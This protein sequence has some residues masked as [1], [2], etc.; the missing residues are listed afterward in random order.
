MAVVVVIVA[1]AFAVATWPMEVAVSGTAEVARDG[2][3]EARDTVL[4]EVDV[5]TSSEASG[6]SSSGA[7]TLGSGAVWAATESAPGFA[8]A[9]A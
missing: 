7:C 9:D 3:F 2:E 8:G 1:A 6:K 5:T 4:D